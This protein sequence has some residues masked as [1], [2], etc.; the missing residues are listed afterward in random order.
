MLVIR[1]QFCPDLHMQYHAILCHAIMGPNCTKCD[2]RSPTAPMHILRWF[3][4]IISYPEGQTTMLYGQSK[5]NCQTWLCM[6]ITRSGLGRPK[7]IKQNSREIY[8]WVS[9]RTT[10]WSYIFLALIH[11]YRA[12]IQ[13]YTHCSKP[14]SGMLWADFTHILQGYCRILPTEQCWGM[15]VDAS[16]K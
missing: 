1:W 2:A 13:Y 8:Q 11:Q 6:W 4:P 14:C 16:V 10:H 9:A 5:Y 3:L 12:Y 7:P 15:W